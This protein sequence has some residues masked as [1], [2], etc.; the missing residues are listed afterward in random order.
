MLRVSRFRPR[1]KTSGQLS[2]AK[3]KSYV[4]A[5]DVTDEMLDFVFLDCS[6][7][8]IIDILELCYW[9]THLDQEV[10]ASHCTR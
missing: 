6:R 2:E 8:D 9:R 10:S 1:V 7:K 3:T 4:R 5:T